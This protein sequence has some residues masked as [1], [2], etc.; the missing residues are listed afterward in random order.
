MPGNRATNDGRGNIVEKARQHEHHDKQHQA[1]LPIVR[2]QRGH[3]VGN[4]AFLEVARQQR[5]SHQQKK[6][7]AE[8]GK[9]VAHMQ[10]EPRK[11]GTISE[12]REGQFVCSNGGE[13]A[14]RDWQRLPVKQRDAEQCQ[15]KKNEIERNSEDQNGFSQC[16]LD[17]Y[18]LACRFPAQSSPEWAPT[19]QH[20]P[21]PPSPAMHAR[22]VSRQVHIKICDSQCAQALKSR[23]LSGKCDFCETMPPP[24]SVFSC[25]DS[26]LP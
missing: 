26:T 10:A 11:A 18:T 9:L 20:R 2:Q 6:Q 8:E 3:L 1:A 23:R 16:G 25:P 5:K 12:T 4:G 21:N 14:K 19:G 17:P 13:T 24:V 22:L 15:G 7:I